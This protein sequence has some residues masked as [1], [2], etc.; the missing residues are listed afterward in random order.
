M[1]IKTRGPAVESVENLA[2]ESVEFMLLL[3]LV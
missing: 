2:V 1:N 3:K